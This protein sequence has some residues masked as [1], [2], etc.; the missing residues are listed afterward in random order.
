[1]APTEY[2][3][4][5]GEAMY[6]DQERYLPAGTEVV[7]VCRNTTCPTYV[8]SDNQYPEKVKKF[9]DNK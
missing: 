7:Y 5:C 3:P 8:Q 4:S 1:M 9:I 2:C 6:A